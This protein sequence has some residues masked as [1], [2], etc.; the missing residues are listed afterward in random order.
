MFPLLT[1]SQLQVEQVP[2][3]LHV[4]ARHQAFHLVSQLL[5]LDVEMDFILCSRKLSA[6]GAGRRHQ[7]A[8]LQKVGEH[9]DFRYSVLS[10][11][12]PDS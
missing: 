11:M 3:L 7:V 6:A 10:A 4:V 5:Q 12:F 8:H 2:C 1:F 9:L